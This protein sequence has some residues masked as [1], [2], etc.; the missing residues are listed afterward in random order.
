MSRKDMDAITGVVHETLKKMVMIMI[1]NNTNDSMK[2]NLPNVVT[3][4]IRLEREKVKDDI[5]AMVADAIKKERESIRAELSVQVTN[6]V[7]N[8]V[9]SQKSNK[10]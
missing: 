7:A 8:N 3:E 1:D 4:A 9:P 2:K 5:A 6:D 10:D